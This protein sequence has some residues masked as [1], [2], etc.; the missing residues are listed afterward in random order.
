MTATVIPTITHPPDA[1]EITAQIAQLI[2]ANVDDIAADDN[3]VVL[4][5]G[6]LE[7]MRLVTRWRRAGLTVDFGAV[8]AEPTVT[9]WAR[10]LQMTD[11]GMGAAR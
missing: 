3:L 5:L 7:M 10:L 4:G 9:A 2:A 8:V 11:S 1:T 6:S